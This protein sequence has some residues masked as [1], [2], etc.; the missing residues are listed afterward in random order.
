MNLYE[1]SS[2]F[3]AVSGTY[4]IL[5]FEAPITTIENIIT[6]LLLCHVKVKLFS[7]NKIEIDN[8]SYFTL[9]ESRSIIADVVQIVKR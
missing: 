9:N 8:N 5:F 3:R 4:T 7:K 1:G 6:V 2:K